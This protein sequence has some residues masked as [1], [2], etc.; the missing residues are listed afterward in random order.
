MNSPFDEQPAGGNGG[1]GGVSSQSGIRFSFGDQ[2]RAAMSP[3][4]F[5]RSLGKTDESEATDKSAWNRFIP[6]PLINQKQKTKSYR[7]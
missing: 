6:T 5:A 2:P 1:G 3:I 4:P 7:K